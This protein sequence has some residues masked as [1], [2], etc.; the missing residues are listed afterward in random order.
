MNYFQVSSP[1][2]L[3]FL[4]SPEEGVAFG[5]SGGTEEK[6]KAVA[7]RHNGWQGSVI[8]VYWPLAIVWAFFAYGWL[9]ALATLFGAVI[10]HLIYS[11]AQASLRRRLMFARKTD[12]ALDAADNVKR[13]VKNMVRLSFHLSAECAAKFLMRT[14]FATLG[15]IQRTLDGLAGLAHLALSDRLLPAPTAAR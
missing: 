14:R 6:V 8:Q 4:D 5:I 3:D 10:G 13:F 2:P 9:G 1:N 15:A 7:A 11:L 12:K